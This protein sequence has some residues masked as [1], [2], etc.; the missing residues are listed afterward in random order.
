MGQ[1]LW[2]PCVTESCDMKIDELRIGVTIIQRNFDRHAVDLEVRILRGLIIAFAFLPHHIA[3]VVS[4]CCGLLLARRLWLAR[5]LRVCAHEFGPSGLPQH[6]LCLSVGLSRAAYRLQWYDAHGQAE[7]GHDA[8]Q[9][10]SGDL[11]RDVQDD[12]PLVGLFQTSKHLGPEIAHRHI[13]YDNATWSHFTELGEDFR[14]MASG[15]QSQQPRLGRS[16]SRAWT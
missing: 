14:G 5:C 11:I 4:R 15:D 16:S 3:R 2:Q 8:L 12:V 10:V 1:V 13:R 7:A 6:P 9:G